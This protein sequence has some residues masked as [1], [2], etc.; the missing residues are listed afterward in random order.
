M[1]QLSGRGIPLWTVSVVLVWAAIGSAIDFGPEEVIQAGGQDIQVPGYSVPSFEDVNGDLL[2]DLIVGQGSGSI[3]G[4]VRVYPNVG[5]EAEPQFDDFFYVQS[6]GADLVCSGSGCMGCFPRLVY[7]DAD[8]FKDLL[9]GQ[10]NGTIQVFLNVGT[11][12]EPVFGA[13]QD[14]NVGADGTVL[15][16]GSRATPNLV[17]WNAD[18]LLD[19]VSGAYDGRIH[20]FTNDG[21]DDLIPCFLSSTTTGEFVLE[22]ETVLAVPGSRSSPVV[23]D[24]NGDGLQDLL[25]GNTYG[26]ILFYANV[27]TETVPAF[28]GYDVVTSDG[29][30]IDLTGS[31]RSRPDVCTWTGDGHFGPADGY[32]DLLIGSG[33][34]KVRLYRGIPMVG[35]FDADGDI[36]V[37]DLRTFM[38]AWRNPEPPADSIADLNADGVLDTADLEAFI[39]LMLAA[40]PADDASAEITPGS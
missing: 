14:V 15:D 22:D 29:Q 30:T 24:L 38:E 27:G 40:N 28:D 9:V 17:D 35:D 34:G 10:S 11:A 6:D 7:W 4:R 12:E 31:P 21:C 1:N 25:V 20:I 33:D 16:V 3:A 39:D 8:E 19:L 5:T 13:G 36:D 23:V 18:G 2:K 26:E 37:D 32:W